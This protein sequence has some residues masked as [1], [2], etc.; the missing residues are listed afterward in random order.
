M[1]E[2]KSGKKYRK[3]QIYRLEVPEFPCLCC[4][5]CCSKFQ[6]QLSLSEARTLAANLGVSWDRF[7]A[8]YTDPR[9]PGTRNFLLRHVDDACI[10]LGPS[11]DNS[12]RLCRI[13]DFKP[14]CCREWKPGLDH[15]E[16]REGLKTTWDLIPDGTG[17]IGGSR[18]RI[19]AFRAFYSIK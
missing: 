9:W 15:A 12:R 19:E 6:P 11:E 13:H 14:A 3:R 1:K 8:D 17:K 2:S 5:T 16:C 18:G 7:L 4:G 10:F